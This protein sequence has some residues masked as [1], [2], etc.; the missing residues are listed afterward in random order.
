M[1]PHLAQ[2]YNQNVIFLL[3]NEIFL[4]VSAEQREQKLFIFY[5]VMINANT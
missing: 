1:L 3:K 2:L 4:N 5:A